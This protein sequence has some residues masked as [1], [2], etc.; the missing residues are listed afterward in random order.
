MN[1][2]G[3]TSDFYRTNHPFDNQT[4]WIRNYSAANSL[5]TTVVGNGQELGLST[6]RLE[7]NTSG[8]NNRCEMT[9]EPKSADRHSHRRYGVEQLE[10]QSHSCCPSIEDSNA[11]S[12]LSTCLMKY[13]VPL[14]TLK[15]QRA[16]TSSCI[17]QEAVLP[18]RRHRAFEDERSSKRLCSPDARYEYIK[19]SEEKQDGES[20]L[21]RKLVDFKS[22]NEYFDE[23][24]SQGDEDTSEVIDKEKIFQQLNILKRGGYWKHL[25]GNC[26]GGE[27]SDG[28][29]IWHHEDIF[30]HEDRLDRKRKDENKENGRQ[31]RHPNIQI[32]S[33]AQEEVDFREEEEFHRNSVG[34]FVGSALTVNSKIS[35]MDGPIGFRIIEITEDGWMCCLDRFWHCV[36]NINKHHAVD[37][38]GILRQALVLLYLPR[39]VAALGRQGM[40]ISD[41]DLMK[42]R[43]NGALEPHTHNSSIRSINP[44]VGRIS[45]T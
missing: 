30:I 4:K 15:A 28:D 39:R 21:R 33:S 29:D 1:L 22:H 26:R 19:R 13:R 32:M 38:S 2:M 43:D 44:L 10:L 7:P 5:S 6:N 36:C 42:R 35:M 20:N 24:E 23:Q 37:S 14:A 45:L 3:S 18:K 25:S 34:P 31:A 8:T 11:L 27:F 12:T 40:V 16:F 17:R 9:R 41:I